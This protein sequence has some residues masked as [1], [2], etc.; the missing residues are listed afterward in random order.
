MEE[1]ISSD[2]SKSGGVKD[3]NSDSAFKERIMDWDYRTLVKF[4]R[5]R[6]NLAKPLRIY[7]IFGTIIFWLI[8]TVIILAYG[9]NVN[10][11]FLISLALLLLTGIILSFPIVSIPKRLFRRYRPYNDPKFEEKFGL[12][13]ENRDPFFGNG[14][15]SFPSGHAF[16]SL[17]VLIIFTYKFGTIGFIVLLIYAVIMLFAR[18]Y[19]GVHFPIDVITGALL[20]AL[21]GFLTILIFPILMPYYDWFWA[22]IKGIFA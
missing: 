9:M 20:G 11:D 7:S 2:R 15:Y 13:I 16:Y 3:N 4:Y 5:F 21:T 22:I 1:S 12:K 14:K 6:Y 17:F 19:L 10:N 8:L 18:I